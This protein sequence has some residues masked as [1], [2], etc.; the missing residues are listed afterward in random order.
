MKVLTAVG[1]CQPHAYY[2][3]YD[4]LRTDSANCTCRFRSSSGRLLTHCAVA[5]NGLV[6]RLFGCM[7]AMTDRDA[8]PAYTYLICAETSELGLSSFALRG[9]IGLAVAVVITLFKRWLD[10]VALSK[11]KRAINPLPPNGSLCHR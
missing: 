6:I 10:P 2:A 5:A 8:W 3:T 1:S 11:R 7:P 4:M 9:L